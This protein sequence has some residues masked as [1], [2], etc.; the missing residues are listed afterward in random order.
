VGERVVHDRYGFG[1]V[2]K[3]SGAGTG[4]RAT[5]DFDDHGTKQLMLAMT[6]LRR[7]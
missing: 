1:T 3:T 7:P 6:P 5:V 2:V 4:A